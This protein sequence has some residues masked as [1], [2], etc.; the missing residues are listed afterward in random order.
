MVL[1]FDGVE[2]FKRLK[3][4]FFVYV[5]KFIFIILYFIIVKFL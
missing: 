1:L 4:G 3:V 2:L 5:G